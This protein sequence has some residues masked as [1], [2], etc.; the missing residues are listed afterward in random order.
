[1]LKEAG[2]D[3]TKLMEEGSTRNINELDIGNIDFVILFRCKDKRFHG[4]GCLR[5][6]KVDVLP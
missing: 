6:K 5:R 2:I 1:M 4:Q 3:P